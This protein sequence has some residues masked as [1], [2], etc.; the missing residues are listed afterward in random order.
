MSDIT[1]SITALVDSLPSE[2]SAPAALTLGNALILIAE[3]TARTPPHEARMAAD[4]L[5][6]AAA[7][8]ANH[9]CAAQPER[10]SG[11][12]NINS[13]LGMGQLLGNHQ[14]EVLKFSREGAWALMDYATAK[15][16]IGKALALTPVEMTPGV[17]AEVVR[18]AHGIVDGIADAPDGLKRVVAGEYIA[19]VRRACE[20][21][22]DGAVEGLR[23]GKGVVSGMD[24]GGCVG[25]RTGVSYEP[26]RR[27]NPNSW[28]LPVWK[29]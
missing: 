9:M 10:R 4:L 5:K 22:A 27:W 16:D 28:P 25:E 3:M 1:T 14:E 23:G 12:T 13:Y 15:S 17:A 24:V 18:A 7:D 6:R 21:V 19:C 20:G 11:D 2:K 26:V 29:G 8:M